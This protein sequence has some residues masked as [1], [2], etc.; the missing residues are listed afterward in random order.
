MRNHRWRQR[1][2][3]WFMPW[4]VGPPRLFRVWRPLLGMLTA[5]AVVA[6]AIVYIPD[7]RQVFT[8][9]HGWETSTPTWHAE[10]QCVGLSAGPYDFGIHEFAHVM[11][12][13]QKQNDAAAVNC[14]DGTPVTIGVLLSL[15][16]PSVGGRALDELEGMAAAQYNADD[17]NCLHPVKLLVG[18][19]GDDQHGSGPREV[20][21]AMAVRGD[22]VA[23]AGV[24]LSYQT[25]TEVIETLAAAQIP[26][27]GDVVTAEGFDRDGSRT[28][29]P[30]YDGCAARETYQRGVAQDYFYRVA[31][32]VGAQIDALAAIH[33]PTPDFVM[34]PTGTTDPYTC[35]ALPLLD[36]A[37]HTQVPSV[38]FDTDEPSTVVQTAERV[39]AA[40]A[41]VTVAYLARGRDLSRFLTSVDQEIGNGQCTPHS[42]TVIATSDAVRLTTPESDPVL[43]DLRGN[44]L[45]SA[46]FT[47]GRV[48]LL[49]SMIADT[50]RPSDDN[51]FLDYKKAF[52][53][54]RLDRE[55]LDQGWA[56]N[57]YDAVTTIA[58]AVHT[59][60][61]HDPVT[62]GNVNVA[63]SGYNTATHSIPGAGGN[64]YFDNAGN[65]V[66]A[67][68]AV[69][70]VC[71][72]AKIH[73]SHGPDTVRTVLVNQG[74][75]C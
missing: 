10:H 53:A 49:S 35:T 36:R 74:E 70:Q 41:D 23:V 42:I 6:T 22:V 5:A 73:D 19:L 20:A 62:R 12:V 68:P 58:T 48:R 69:V 44:A 51:A 26:M 24:G 27:I 14:P 3:D 30:I 61:Q 64:I 33:P 63:I 21:Q 56:V 38:K 1:L 17:L 55:R 65:R 13:I 54:A 4:T 45:S 18:Q 25:T 57:G 59:L 39:C 32:R 66:G 40:T 2:K 47:D 43:E 67:A 50:H 9:G 71:P 46:S 28:D 15:T 72:V 7:I 37:F 52:T 16:D 75:H 34:V 60:H 8:C 31:F 29:N 11:Q